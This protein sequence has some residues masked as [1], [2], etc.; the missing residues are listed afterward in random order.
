MW[1]DWARFVVIGV[2]FPDGLVLRDDGGVVI[3]RWGSWWS[4]S[5]NCLQRAVKAYGCGQSAVASLLDMQY[6]IKL[7]MDWLQILLRHNRSY[8][9]LTRGYF[10]SFFFS[11]RSPNLYRSYFFVFLV[12]SVINYINYII[13][14]K[15]YYW[16]VLWSNVVTMFC[17]WREEDDFC[18]V[19]SCKM[20]K[21]RK[22]NQSV[23]GC[24]RCLQSLRIVY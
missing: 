16:F 18:F 6:I 2:L 13:I 22:S 14:F 4:L 12:G 20:L 7:R 24:Y 10:V 9:N 11:F 8:E 15:Q 1:Q 21:C 3:H 5:P 23:H 17:D 19:F